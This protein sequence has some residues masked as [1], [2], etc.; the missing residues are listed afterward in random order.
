[1]QSVSQIGPERGG[2]QYSP[3]APGP[4]SIRMLRVF[5]AVDNAAPIQCQLFSYCLSDERRGRHLYEGLSYVWGS[6]DKSQAIF[7]DNQYLPVTANLHAALLHLR[8]AAIERV[9]WIDAICINQADPIERGGQVQLMA[10]IYSEAARVIVWLGPASD[11]SDTILEAIRSAAS[12]G[13]TSLHETLLRK[14]IDELLARPWFRRIWVLQEAAAARQVRLH[15]GF[16]DLDGYTFSAGLRALDRQYPG[17]IVL[18]RAV[19]PVVYTVGR[20]IFRPRA[21]PCSSSTRSFSLNIRPLGELIEMYNRHEATERQDKIF[22]LLGMSVDNP[23][24]AGLVPNYTLRWAEVFS[25]TIAFLLGGDVSAQTWEGHELAIIEGKGLVIGKVSKVDTVD[26][27]DNQA[28]EIITTAASGRPGVKCTLSLQSLS[29]AVR[30]G[31][32]VCLLSGAS[33]PTIVRLCRDYFT[34]VRIQVPM[35]LKGARNT[36]MHE[37]LLL[38]D[39]EGSRQRSSEVAEYNTLME[40]LGPPGTHSQRMMRLWHAAMILYQI[41]EF[42]KSSIRMQGSLEAHVAELGEEDSRTLTCMQKSAVLHMILGKNAQAEVLFKRVIMLA[43]RRPELDEITTSSLSKLAA[44]YRMQERWPDA[45]KLRLMEDTIYLMRKGMHSVGEIM[46]KVTKAL[47][48]DL[49]TF[50]FERDGNDVQVTEDLL[51]RIAK[52]TRGVELMKLVFDHKGTA[53][54]IT[55]AVIVAAAR[56]MSHGK[57][58]IELLLERGGNGFSLSDRILLA[59]AE[60][61]ESGSEIIKLLLERE[62]GKIAVNGTVV[63][64]AAQYV[65]EDFLRILM[66]CDRTNYTRDAHIQIASKFDAEFMK[67]LLAKEG[68]SFRPTEDILIAAAGNRNARG[69]LD[70]LFEERGNEI[71]ITEDFIAAAVSNKYADGVTQLLLQRRRS[72]VELS[73][74]VV[75]AA[76][77]SWLGK[78]TMKL[79]LG[80]QCKARLSEGLVAAVARHFD[81]DI[82][83]L[84]LDS[85]QGSIDVTEAV[86]TS[87]LKRENGED[88]LQLLFRT[89]RDTV[90]VKDSAIIQVAKSCNDETMKLLLD[91]G[92]GSINITDAILIAAARNKHGPS[93]LKLLLRQ[94]R[95]KLQISEE[96]IIEVVRKG[97][98][99][100][101]ALLDEWGHELHLTED[102]LAAAAGH[103]YGKEL[104]QLLFERKPAEIRITEKVIIAAAGSK[105][106]QEVMKLLVDHSPETV[107]AA[108]AIG[109][110]R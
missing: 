8:D 108:D 54:P 11:Q 47:D 35:Q 91:G 28:I 10:K 64:A 18:R 103:W 71:E 38:W 20:A 101:R 63:I 104:L 62:R 89:K 33:K 77:A 44:I 76:A 86:V 56:N 80:R 31:D 59:A 84:L 75:V 4:N 19:A 7:I 29:N 67:M 58:I 32:I 1:M 61:N 95:D 72:E 66:R 34:I 46:A 49:L 24:A 51:I 36:I 97:R 78:K 98:E 15:C 22:A 93:M 107:R 42:A 39:W 109:V 12:E 68:E 41:E 21:T 2:Y 81:A 83:S 37:F 106:H 14:G 5:P 13:T 55:D 57:A 70:V 105:R 74:R 25:Q 9:I 79:L 50:M 45:Q 52:E 100:L 17:L 26:A 3:L 85:I 82:M 92:Q 48:K 102:I 43:R 65:N 40:V 88:I 53:L 6:T 60:N 90:H 73:E 16:I 96:L 23:M 30:E 27:G 69:V 99:A 87:A 110:A 94:I